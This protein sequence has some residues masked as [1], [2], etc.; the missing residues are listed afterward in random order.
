MLNYMLSAQGVSPQ[1]LWL[2]RCD[3]TPD[4]CSVIIA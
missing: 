2:P 4:R 3:K 1:P